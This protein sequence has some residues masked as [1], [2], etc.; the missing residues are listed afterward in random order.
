MSDT[1]DGKYG[2]GGLGGWEAVGIPPVEAHALSRAGYRP[3]EARDWRGAGAMDPGTVA[4]WE[5][6]GFTPSTAQPWMVIGEVGP[7]DAITMGDAG[8]APAECARVRASDP[9][10]VSAVTDASQP[11]IEEQ[12]PAVGF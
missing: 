6:Y 1:S 4:D 12:P 5:R 7:A 8:M 3:N 10:C 11:E 9:R 2:S